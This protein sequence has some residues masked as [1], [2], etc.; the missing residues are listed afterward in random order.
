L[1][2]AGSAAAGEKGKHEGEAVHVAHE[3]TPGAG[4][5]ASW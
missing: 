1:R 2:C 5:R 4:G 3:I